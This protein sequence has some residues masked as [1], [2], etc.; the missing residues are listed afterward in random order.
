MERPPET[1][2]TEPFRVLITTILSQR[3]RDE[4]TRAAARNLY[5]KYKNPKELANAKPGD[6]EPLIMAA[7][8]P[9]QKAVKI[10]E[11]SKVILKE[12]GGGVPDD[13]DSLVKL[14]GVGRKTANCVLAYGF[15][16][17]AIAV[18]THVHRISN[19]WGLARTR[20]P[21]VTEEVLRRVVPEKYWLEINRL[22]VRHGQ[23]VCNPVRPRCG[24]CRISHLCDHGLYFLKF[25]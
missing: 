7:G 19:L 17:P 5:E 3:T 24:E 25:Q 2:E 9:R 6:V 8:F 10:I 14:P 4:N 20:D 18:D 15:G 23:R 1:D 16:Q 13:L 11:T 12:H 22:M 21:E